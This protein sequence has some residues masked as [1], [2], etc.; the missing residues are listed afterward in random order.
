MKGGSFHRLF[1]VTG[2]GTTLVPEQQ[3]NTP[4]TGQ[5]YHRIDDAADKAILATAD[6][7]HKVKLEQTDAAP[8]ESADDGEDQCQCIHADHNS[9]F[10]SIS[11]RPADS[12]HRQ[13]AKYTK[14]GQDELAFLRFSI[15]F[16]ICQNIIP[17]IQLKRT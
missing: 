9:F 7:R 12:M 2:V 13:K 1:P 15:G 6:P 3:G 11:E 4:D 14:A 17:Y 16:S 5:R 10:E 8:V